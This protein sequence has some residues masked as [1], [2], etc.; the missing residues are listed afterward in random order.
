[1]TVSDPSTSPIIL[2]LGPTATGKSAVAIETALAVQGE[3]ISA[4]SR[5][6]FRELDIVTDKPT[7]AA[8]RGVTHHLLDIVEIDGHY[9]A[10]SFRGDVERLLPKIEQ[11]GHLPLVV[12]GGTLYLGAL[13]RG[14]FSGPSADE[15]LRETLLAQP[16][17]RLYQRLEEVDP[18]AA[19][20][21]HENDRLRVVRALEVY[22]LTGQPISELQKKARPIAH[23][24]VPFGLKRERDDHRQAIA[25]RVEEMFRRG[26]IN[27]VAHLRRS[28]LGPGHQAYR[29]IGVRETF[30]YLD[31]E[32]S[33]EQLQEQI[34]HKTWALARRQMAWFRNDC[35]IDWIDITGQTPRITAEEIVRKYNQKKGFLTVKPR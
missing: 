26:L 21:I 8:R 28:G 2:I 35:G 22:E 27:E 18:T 9:D 20:K 30:A 24:F 34:V 12:G 3:V 6:F 13:M 1:M 33:R 25:V 4:D 11:R 31:G 16:L 17:A 5:A 14:I 32:I 7:L 23:P 15:G 10:I 19:T 29:T